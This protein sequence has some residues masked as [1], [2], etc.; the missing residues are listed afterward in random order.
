MAVSIH[1]CMRMLTYQIVLLILAIA[2]LVLLAR[3]LH[4]ALALFAA[5]IL[6]GLASGMAV[7]Y[8][9]QSIGTGFARTV[10]AVGL[11]ILAATLLAAALR[12][13]GA[14]FR[15][16]PATLAAL[17]GIGGIGASTQAAYAVLSNYAGTRGS[18]RAG[19]LALSLNAG[20]GLL[21]PSPVMIAAVAIV[22]APVWLSLAFGVALAVPVIAL[23]WR[24]GL[25]FSDDDR[26]AS[27]PDPAATEPPRRLVLPAL[28][29]L[30]LL[31]IASLGH[32]PSEPFGGGA[33]RR[34]L[35][36]FGE[37]AL[38]LAVAAL[39]VWLLARPR[40][41]GSL[42]GK[43]W[44]AEAILAAAPLLVLTGLAGGF[45]TVVQNTGTPEL[46]AE[47]VLTA[48]LGVAV[49]FLAAAIVRA[50]GGSALTAA[51]TAAGMAAP[52]LPVLGLDSDAGRA[53]CAV[54]VGAGSLAALHVTEPLFWQ[55][56]QAGNA[57]PGRALKLLT[58]PSVLQALLALVLIALL[59]LLA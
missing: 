54:S 39:G 52:L 47:Q 7:D 3:R 20:H 27:Q 45:A 41:P 34:M 53:L 21:W 16:A 26:D 43:G 44:T 35:L 29:I 6:Y 32:L 51:I 28:A 24:L 22:G 4:M 48:P 2:V 11:P 13:T 33:T 17:G 57:T 9:A 49:P 23:G 25:A 55:A 50:L 15:L 14:A 5:A 37:P 31:G 30:L 10:E 8:V 58:L 12:G 19:V 38:L 59:A 1:G 42:G 46:V 36:G 40:S 56:A 18:A